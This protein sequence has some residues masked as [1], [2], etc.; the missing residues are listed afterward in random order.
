MVGRASHRRSPDAKALAGSSSSGGGIMVVTKERDRTGGY[1]GLTFGI[2]SSTAGRWVSVADGDCGMG[3]RRL[4][5]TGMGTGN[6]AREGYVPSSLIPV[7]GRV[8]SPSPLRSA[9]AGPHAPLGEP[10]RARRE[11]DGDS[12]PATPTNV[13]VGRLHAVSRLVNTLPNAVAPGSPS[14][15]PAAAASCPDAT[16]PNTFRGCAPARRAPRSRGCAATS[17]PSRHGPTA[18]STSERR[19]PP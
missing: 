10:A 17:T 19:T 2:R 12:T 6:S 18:A 11:N 16:I 8:P 14:A 3:T 15:S 7:P 1:N 5:G 13:N 9:L 4:S